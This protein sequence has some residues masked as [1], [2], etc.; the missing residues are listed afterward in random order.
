MLPSVLEVPVLYFVIVYYALIP[1]YVI[2]MPSDNL[3]KELIHNLASDLPHDIIEKLFNPGLLLFFLFLFIC[4]WLRLSSF[5]VV[6][7]M[8]CQYFPVFWTFFCPQN[9]IG[10][11]TLLKMYK[12]VIVNFWPFCKLINNTAFIFF[13]CVLSLLHNKLCNY[14]ADSSSG[15]YWRSCCWCR[16]QH[17]P[18]CYKS[19]DLG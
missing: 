13:H 14:P 11:N 1:V 7:Q 3:I 16:G 18:R 2:V 5:V 19:Q 15:G 4:H 8:I 9:L 6:A 12:M 17:D 10:F